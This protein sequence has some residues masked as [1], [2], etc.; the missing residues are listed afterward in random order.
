MTLPWI[1]IV[2]IFGLGVMFFYVGP[3]I[4]KFRQ[5]LG[6]P[7]QLKS[8]NLSILQKIQLTLLGLKTPLLATLAT[9]WSFIAQN[10]DQL[11]GFGWEKFMTAEHAAWVQAGLWLAT[12]WA[13]FSGIN[14]VAAMPPAVPAPPA[15]PEG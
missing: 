4:E 12:L 1:P 9:G 5:T 15:P 13:H 10:G 7:D 14:T 2:I 6:V 3:Q 8:G 11:A